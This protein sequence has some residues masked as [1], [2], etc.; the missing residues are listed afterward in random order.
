MRPTEKPEYN[1]VIIDFPHSEKEFYKLLTL[2]DLDQRIAD[3]PFLIEKFE[4]DLKFILSSSFADEC[5]FCTGFYT[6][7]TV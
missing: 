4:N 2:N 3:Q 1:S 6:V 5:Y 7:S